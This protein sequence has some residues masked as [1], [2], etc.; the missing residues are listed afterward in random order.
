MTDDRQRA[1]TIQSVY[2]QWAAKDR[3]AADGA[4]ADTELSEKKITELLEM[5]IAD[6]APNWQHGEIE[7]VPAVGVSVEEAAGLEVPVVED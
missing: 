7:A 3:E 6:M 5:E 4:L 1:N 2:L